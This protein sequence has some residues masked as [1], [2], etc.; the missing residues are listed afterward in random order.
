M[1][2]EDKE[3]LKKELCARLA[4]GIK[5]VYYGS[6]EERDCVDDID[7]IEVFAN[8]NLEISI[9]QYALPIEK[10]KPLL[11]PMASITEEEKKELKEATCPN[12]T[13]YFDD[14]YLIC[15][16]SHFGEQISY[17]FMQDIISW[18][19]AHHFDVYDLIGKGLAVA[20]TDKYNPYKRI[21]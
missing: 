12:G 8:G 16:M 21:W 17:S 4:Y 2:K 9:G 18:L 11:R 13:G 10:V 14:K 7:C 3:L 19:Y 5:G 1:T 20:I 15:P 6:E